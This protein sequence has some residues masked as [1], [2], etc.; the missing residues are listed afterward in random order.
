MKYQD[1]TDEELIVQYRKGDNQILEY[2]LEKHKYIV[3]QE[4]KKLYLLGGETQDLIQ[5]GM[6]GLFK[7]IQNYDLKKDGVFY[8]YARVCVTHNMYTLITTYNRK[9]HMPL[10]SYVSIDDTDDMGENHILDQTIIQQNADPESLYLYQ[11]YSENFSKELLCLLSDLEKEVLLKH[12]AGMHYKEIAQIMS[13][14]PKTIDNTLQ[15]AK[16][17]A[18]KILK[19]LK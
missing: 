6:I 16:N 9:K 17:K 5:E 14:E 13:K 15:R 2:L 11:E 3:N 4:A 12:I 7:A 1:A 10:N 8:T 18:R 19:K